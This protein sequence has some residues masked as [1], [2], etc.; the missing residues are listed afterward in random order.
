MQNLTLS[1]GG[2]GLV[3]TADSPS[4]LAVLRSS[5]IGEDKQT[6]RLEFD[7]QAISVSLLNSSDLGVIVDNNGLTTIHDLSVELGVKCSAVFMPSPNGTV[8]KITP[9]DNGNL[10]VVAV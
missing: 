10:I 8:F 1:D 3:L 6:A 4:N 9:D 2:T 5:G 7:Q